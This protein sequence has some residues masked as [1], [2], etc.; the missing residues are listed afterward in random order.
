M[1]RFRDHITFKLKGSSS[2][3]TFL[4][5][6]S[7]KFSESH[8]DISGMDLKAYDSTC[9]RNLLAYDV[10]RSCNVPSPRSGFATLWVNDV[11][12]GTFWMS[13]FIDKDFLKKRYS[14]PHGILV[15]GDSAILD[16]GIDPASYANSGN[17]EKISGTE[18][19]WNFFAKLGNSNEMNTFDLFPKNFSGIW[20]VD[21]DRLVRVLAG[22]VIT[23]NIDG[24]VANG[25]NWYVYYNPRS[26][27]FELIQHDFDLSLQPV[28]ALSSISTF[29]QIQALIINPK[30]VKVLLKYVDLLIGDAMASQVMERRLQNLSAMLAGEFQKNA[31]FRVKNQVEWNRVPKFYRDD[32]DQISTFVAKRIKYLKSNFGDVGSDF[33]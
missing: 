15:K 14:Q 6:Y 24:L 28:H 18:N 12:M 26:E 5:G 2:R 22:D 23:S 29:T 13:E 3:S 19:S 32:V 8:L 20:F 27:M 10:Y 21:Q 31:I 33:A 11:Q 25:R 7:I 30:N 17:Y 1:I 16:L 4:R 9:L